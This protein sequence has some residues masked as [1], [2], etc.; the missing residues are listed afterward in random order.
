MQTNN[1]KI[2]DYDL[3]LDER[4]GKK[5][6]ASRDEAEKRAYAFYTGKMIEDVRKSAHLTQSELA[7][8]IGTNKSYISRVENG[9][10]EPKVSTLYRI[11]SAL[12]MTVELRPII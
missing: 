6:T 5:G 10:T 4:F 12:G 2:T 9:L 3:V 11:A 7:D 1:H 8:R